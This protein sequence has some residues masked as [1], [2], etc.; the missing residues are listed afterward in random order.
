VERARVD[1]H[2]VRL[3]VAR[4]EH[5]LTVLAPFDRPEAIAP[6]R[7]ILHVRRQ[8]GRA[9]L[10]QLLASTHGFHDARSAVGARLDLWAHQFEPLLSVLGGQR[11]ILIADEVGLGKTIQAGLILAEMN[12]RGHLRHA[13]IIAPASLREQWASEL[14]QRFALEVSSAETA[15][16]LGEARA[17]RAGTNPWTRPG[18]W[19]TSVDFL[20][21]RHVMDGMPFAAW[22]VVILDEAHLAAGRTDRHDACDELGRRARCLVMLSATPHSGDEARFT[23]LLGLGALPFADDRLEI[24]RRTRADVALPHGRVVRWPR[25]A[26]SAQLVRLLD[27]L[28]A[29]ER[30]ILRAARATRRDTALLLLAVFRKRA[31]STVAA[32]DSSLAR[33]L[34]WIDAPAHACTLDWM[35]PR[36]GFGSDDDLDENERATLLAEVGMPVAH[37]RTWLRRLRTLAADALPHDTRIGHIARLVQRTHEPVVIFTEFRDSL[38]HLQH[39][40]ARLRAVAIIHGGQGEGIRQRELVRFTGGAAS[41]LIATDVGG[42]GLNLQGRACWVVNVELPWNPTRIEQRI[43]RV[44]RIGQARRVHAT[45]LTLNH[46]AEH[47]VLASLCRRASRAQQAFDPS[48]LMDIAPPG[49]LAMAATLIE[50]R[51]LPDARPT[52]QTVAPSTT[53]RRRARAL[54]RLTATR[55]RLQDQWRGPEPGGSRPLCAATTIKPRAC[56][57]NPVR[58]GVVM[59][60]GVPILDRAGDA[61]ERHLVAF[62]CNATLV[63]APPSGLRSEL[64]ARA[65]ARL[66]ARLRRLQRLVAHVSQRRIGA[67]QAIALHLHALRYPE[68]AQPELFSQREAKAFTRA[69]SAAGRATV[70]V[71]TWMDTERGRSQLVVGEPTL[72][73]IGIER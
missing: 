58:S 49:D 72:E 14:R 52:A 62:T 61:I 40:L 39:H 44:D 51:C 73:W 31:L 56:R 16:L 23:R 68:E 46:A 57:S 1:R 24:F 54:V 55:R 11:R 38:E 8:K 53:H 2:I 12:R 43:G 70:E 36:L 30:A 35:Q 15:G 64:A 67:E 18:I 27:A 22:D 28:Q 47:P 25:I 9:R 17:G 33:R 48:A 63:P 10:A 60:L 21:Q 37:E 71:R 26:P 20:K 41:V 45:V 32:L 65:V 5:R 19:I 42:Q 50:D 4:H 7:R 3:D 59:L 69:R 6:S 34:E 29:F 66:A 13:L